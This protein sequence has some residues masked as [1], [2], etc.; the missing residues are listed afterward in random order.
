MSEFVAYGVFFGLAAV[1]MLLFSGSGER[2][3]TRALQDI[4]QFKAVAQFSRAS[5]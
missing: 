3:I 2:L 4:R 1:F 5:A